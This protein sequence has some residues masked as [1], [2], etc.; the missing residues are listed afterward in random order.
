MLKY[1]ILI[2][3]LLQIEHLYTMMDSYSMRHPILHISMLFI[4]VRRIR[5]CAELPLMTVHVLTN[6]VIIKHH[7]KQQKNAM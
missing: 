2:A 3:E 4:V 5:Q 6:C 1:H 7:S